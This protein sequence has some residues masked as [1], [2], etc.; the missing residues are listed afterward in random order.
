MTGSLPSVI[1]RLQVIL[2]MV[3]EMKWNEDTTLVRKAISQLIRDLQH[4]L[5][6][7]PVRFDD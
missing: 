6:Y 1:R 5:G 4:E 3:D 2:L 7:Q